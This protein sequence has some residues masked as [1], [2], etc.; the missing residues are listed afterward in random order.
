M[1]PPPSPKTIA[2]FGAG[3]AGLSAAH[4]LSRL[5]HRVSVYEATAEAGGFF[6]SARSEGSG[7]MPT[8]YSWHGLG[9]WYHNA[10]DLLKQIPFDETGSLYEKALSRPIDFGIFPD[11]GSAQFYDRGLLSIPRMFRFARSDFLPWA[12]LMLKTW[13]ANERTQRLYARQNAFEAWR[14]FLRDTGY[15]TWRSC[16]GPWIG[17][18][19]TRASLHTAGQFFRKQLITR[20]AHRHAADA[21]GPAWTQGAGDGWLLFRGPSSDYWFNRW[22][23]LLRAQGVSLTWNEP[24]EALEFDGSVI[25]GA[26]LKSGARVVADAYIL[27]TTPFAAAEILSRTPALEAQPELRC[28]KPLIQD[29]PHVQ[30]SFRLA[31]AEPIRFPRERTAVVVADSEFNLTLFAE[32]QVWLPSVELGKRVESLWTG[33]SCVATVPGRLH[34]LPVMRCTKQQFIDEVKAQVFG[35]GAL[36][37]LI[38]EANGGRRLSDFEL[39]GLEVW[40]EWIFSPEGI[41]GPQPKWVTTTNTQ[42]H[43]P[44]QATPVPNLFLA[45]AHTRTEADVWSIEGAVESGRRAAQALDPRVPVLPQY[46]SRWLR[47]IGAVDDILFKVRAPHVLDLVL[48]L[49]LLATVAAAVI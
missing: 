17:S 34:G 30:V 20:P 15:R 9:P 43:L 45:G 31:F 48:L 38:A 32:E 40:H 47:W 19:W 23:P 22:I 42:P 8:E 24:L 1:P 11:S 25:T 37:A 2:V 33:T 12:W 26:K 13:T 27:A 29:G 18:D 3:I 5:G 14:P 44:R 46:R 36:N 7:D 49:T 35:C 16:F 4:E 28:F 10:F 39:L 6:R 21:E 41:R